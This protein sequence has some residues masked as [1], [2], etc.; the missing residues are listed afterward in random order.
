M[1]QKLVNQISDFEEFSKKGSPQSD[2]IARNSE[3]SENKRE[4][5][6][7]AFVPQGTALETIS[8]NS[9]KTSEIAS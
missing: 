5:I 3:T 2:N 6:L 8:E 9:S 7:N 4:S 1:S